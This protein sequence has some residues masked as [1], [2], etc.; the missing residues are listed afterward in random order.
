MFVRS[1]RP[2]PHATLNAAWALLVVDG[3]GLRPLF[4]P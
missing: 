2:S 4:L 1:T 3:A